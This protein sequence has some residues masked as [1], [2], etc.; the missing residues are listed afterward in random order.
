MNKEEINEQI[1]E[2]GCVVTMTWRKMKSALQ[3]S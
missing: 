1:G 3:D 2:K